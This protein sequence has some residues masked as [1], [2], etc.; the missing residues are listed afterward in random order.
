[1]AWSPNKLWRS[2]PPYLTYGLE[3][4]AV[5]AEVAT[6]WVRKAAD[7]AVLKN[8]QKKKNPKIPLQKKRE[9]RTC[10]K[11]RESVD[12]ARERVQSSHLSQTNK[13]N[14][15]GDIAIREKL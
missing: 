15:G 5:N 1:L 7:E 14:S 3:R 4:L 6:V 9:V 8:V 11:K 13:L 10:A 2:I 12:A